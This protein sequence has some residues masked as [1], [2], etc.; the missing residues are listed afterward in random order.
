MSND[1]LCTANLSGYFTELNNADTA[2][3]EA[4]RSG[5]NR[6][7]AAAPSAASPARLR[8]LPRGSQSDLGVELE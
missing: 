1:L 8:R 2:L 7:A 3:Y 5:R 6:V 4:K